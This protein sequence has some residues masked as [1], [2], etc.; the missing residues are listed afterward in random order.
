MS[1]LKII[2]VILI[3]FPMTIYSQ[4]TL[5]IQIGG[6]QN[7]KGKVLLVLL[8]KNE[9]MIKEFYGDIRE[10][11]CI[12]KIEDIKPGKYS[13][14]YF[15]DENNNKKLDTNYFGIPTE[16]FG[17]SNN[18]KGT[19]GPPSFEKTIFDLKGERSLKCT[20]KYY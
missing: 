1:Y 8:D 10:N 19:F 4:N 2:F 20:P 9:N 15:H 3:L 18:V 5:T 7:N 14:K 13:F 11:K 6:L 17:F 12:V 16:G